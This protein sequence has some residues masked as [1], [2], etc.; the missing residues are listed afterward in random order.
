MIEKIEAQ[1]IKKRYDSGFALECSLSLQRGVLY[2]VVGPNGSGK[3]TLLRIMGLLDRPDTGSIIYDNGKR[4]FPGPFRDIRLRRQVVLVPTRAILFN[5]TVY[6]NAAYGLR[7]RNFAKNHISERVLTSLDEVGLSGRGNAHAYELSSGEAQRLALARALAL[8]P[9]VLLLD[10]P[11]ASL[12]PDSTRTIE[13]IIRR[14]VKNSG[15]IT[16]IVTHNLNQA[17]SLSDS[18]IFMYK[19]RIMEISGPSVFFK[20]PATEL[21]RKFVFGEIY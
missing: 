19:G 18:V 3:S 13:D 21:A 15:K 12:D 5:E 9:A 7:L 4:S 1:D 14:K 10:E 8:D 20:E 16:V 2:S 11:T 6:D 17:R